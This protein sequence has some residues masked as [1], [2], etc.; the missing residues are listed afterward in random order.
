MSDQSEVTVVMEECTG[1][2]AQQ[3]LL[4]FGREG[5]GTDIS[6]VAAGTWTLSRHLV[7]IV[8]ADARRI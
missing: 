3:D 6:Q 4:A 5:S 1:R 7:S 2:M 8:A